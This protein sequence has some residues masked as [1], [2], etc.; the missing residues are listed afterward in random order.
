MFPGV[1][2][3]TCAFVSPVVNHSC[4]GTMS[5]HGY[6]PTAVDAAIFTSFANVLI[7]KCD[8]DPGK[9]IA[10]EADVT[11]LHDLPKSIGQQLFKLK[12][13]FVML[14]PSVDFNFKL[15]SK[16]HAIHW[17]HAG[18][19]KTWGA[20]A[21]YFDTARACAYRRQITSNI[22]CVPLDVAINLLPHQVARV[23]VALYAVNGNSTHSGDATHRA[24]ARTM[25]KARRFW[26]HA[27]VLRLS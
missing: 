2:V 15:P 7:D 12:V 5:Y 10:L 25:K 18:T 14:A 24:L 27:K 4:T 9:Y 22:G 23:P 6:T 19:L 3:L 11:T 26:E 1:T 13:P 17:F 16:H 8:H 20:G 21:I